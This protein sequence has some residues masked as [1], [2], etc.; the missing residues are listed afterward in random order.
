MKITINRF[1][2]LKKNVNINIL[3]IFTFVTMVTPISLYAQTLP[4]LPK[5]NILLTKSNKFIPVT[6]KGIKILPHDPLQLSFIIDPGD[7][8][9]RGKK[10]QNESKILIKYFLAA[11]TVPTE[12]QWVN[13]S[14]AESNRIITD[15]FGKTQLGRD[16]LAQDYLLKQFTAALIY[17]EK[18]IGHLF[19]DKIY[20]KAKEKLG[21]TNIP[22]D[23]F[24]KVWVVPEK[25]VVYQNEN[26]VYV[27]DSHLKVMTDADYLL[28]RQKTSQVDSNAPNQ[29]ER[30]DTKETSPEDTASLILKQI[31]IPKIE[32]EINEGKNFYTL[33][34]MY[35]SVILATWF[36]RNLKESVLGGKYVN[37]NKLKGIALKDL[38][39]KE[40]IYNQYVQAYKSGLYNI[41]KEGYD[42]VNKEVVS[43]KYVAGGLNIAKDTDEAMIA[44]EVSAENFFTGLTQASGPI[45]YEAKVNFNINSPNDSNKKISEEADHAMLSGAEIPE[46]F[47]YQAIHSGE[48]AVFR[49]KVKP[50]YVTDS[51]LQSLRLAT[52]MGGAWQAY[53]GP[54][55]FIRTTDDGTYVF[56]AKMKVTVNKNRLISYTFFKQNKI[57]GEKEWVNAPGDDG[58]IEVFTPLTGRV[59][60]VSFEYGGPLNQKAGGQADVVYGKNSEIAKLTDKDHAPI[61]IIPH[62]QANMKNS[63]IENY[64]KFQW[65]KVE[66]FQH[67]FEFRR[68]GHVHMWSEKATIEGVEV[69]RLMI[70]SDQFFQKLYSN[71]ETEFYETI[72][73][74]RG[75]VELLKHLTE[76]FGIQIDVI[77]SND[78]HAGLVLPLMRGEHSET[79]KDVGHLMLLHNMGYQGQYG[80]EWFDELGLPEADREIVTRW[81]EINMLAFSA[82]MLGPRNR[83][84]TVSPRYALEVSENFASLGFLVDTLLAQNPEFFIGLLNGLSDDW[85]PA[86]DEIL[87]SHENLEFKNYTRDTIDLKTD[88]KRAFQR[89]FS[90][91]ADNPYAKK[92]TGHLVEGSDNF[93]MISANRLEPQKQLDILAH[94]IRKAKKEKKKIDFVII[95]DGIYEEEIIKLALEIQSDPNS[96]VHLVHIPFNPSVERLALAAG[97]GCIAP[98]DFEPGGLAHL[99]GMLYGAVP[100]VRWTGGLADTV[101]EKGTQPSGFGFSGIS[102]TFSDRPA[103]DQVRGILHYVNWGKFIDEVDQEL[104][105]YEDQLGKFEFSD[106]LL[107]EAIGRAFQEEGVLKLSEKKD[108]DALF[109]EESKGISNGWKLT[110]ADIVRMAVNQRQFYRSIVRGL[111]VYES[112]KNYFREVIAVNA[113][114]IK[115]YWSDKIDGYVQLYS[116]LKSPSKAEDQI[117]V[118]VE[119]EFTTGTLKDIKL[120][121]PNGL[122]E[123]VGISDAQSR[124]IP[125]IEE[126]EEH[127]DNAMRTN[128][129]DNNLGG[130]NF[131]TKNFPIQAQGDDPDINIIQHDAEYFEKIIIESLFPEIVEFGPIFNLHLLIRPNK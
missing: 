21:T 126:L 121:N 60:T 56:E 53:E 72:L 64:Q 124:N 24:H 120:I 23:I 112:D 75:A 17:P 101:D 34:Q 61:A 20:K 22:I 50:E 118:K 100:F 92:S 3:I 25:A 80:V 67:D 97:D 108:K 79:F 11:L 74:S 46:N 15:H 47:K 66:G 52:N 122:M 39:D 94:Q 125:S 127:E 81:H 14:P 129:G 62:F 40:K 37:K 88:N 68:K 33:R 95:G 85:N 43:R 31:I 99:K 48:E 38:S 32:K 90:K 86:T 114:N 28:G 57:T 107:F 98:S 130:I 2:S 6:I 131:S 58:L 27:I 123:I 104:K 78:H 65:T 103:D 18:E 13:L 76:T 109:W 96:S 115:A 42:D 93:L 84:I 9:K 91:E 77:E 73:L 19:W 105:P 16:L 110:I 111:E 41:T 116:Q 71:P 29:R 36:K 70:D 106:I 102:R 7:S 4:F 54:I 51:F 26:M 89:L 119:A 44:R 128:R 82:S 1:L 113:M 55:E 63:I 35:H 30:F 45:L 49:L 10:L 59:A 117:D 12:E 8:P 69:Y 87:K 83:V 5:S